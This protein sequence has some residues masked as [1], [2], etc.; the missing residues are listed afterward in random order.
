MIWT[1]AADC[2]NSS[3]N[4][5]PIVGSASSSARTPASSAGEC[6]LRPT[7][8]KSLPFT[9]RDAHALCLAA[10]QDAHLDGLADGAATQGCE[11]VVRVADTLAA[12][13]G[14]DIAHQQAALRRR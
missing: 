9:D 3:F 12:N 1:S 11:D 13:R 4:P 8:I 6:K 5:T 7:R 14:E 10:A 2:S